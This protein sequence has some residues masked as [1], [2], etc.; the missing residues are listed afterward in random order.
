MTDVSITSPRTP[1]QAPRAVVMFRPAL[2]LASAASQFLTNIPKI[3]CTTKFTRQ[4]F[5]HLAKPATQWAIFE[6]VRVM[7]TEI[8][9]SCRKRC[10]RPICSIPAIRRL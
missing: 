6:A 1:E 5:R 10:S 3:S 7:F 4:H 9:V 2:T 8:G